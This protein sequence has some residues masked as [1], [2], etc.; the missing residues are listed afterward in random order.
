MDQPQAIIRLLI[1]SA[2]DLTPQRDLVLQLVGQ[3][4]ASTEPN[5]PSIEWRVLDHSPA[6]AQELQ[7][8]GNIPTFDL[9]IGL[10]WMELT[11]VLDRATDSIHDWEIEELCKIYSDAT[12]MALTGSS[13]KSS[14]AKGKQTRL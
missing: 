1:H 11:P 4:A 14:L 6:S 3:L 8:A 9:L 13:G 2:S 5:L 12:L 10:V 7:P